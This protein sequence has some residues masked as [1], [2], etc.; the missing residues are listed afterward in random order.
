MLDVIAIL[1]RGTSERCCQ[2]KKSHSLKRSYLFLLQVT[3]KPLITERLDAQTFVCIFSEGLPSVSDSPL[4]IPTSSVS[5]FP[6]CLLSAPD[7]TSLPILP[8][9]FALG[10]FLGCWASPP[11]AKRT[12]VWATHSADVKQWICS[13][14]KHISCLSPTSTCSQTML[15]CGLSC[16]HQQEVKWNLCPGFQDTRVI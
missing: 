13:P 3:P 6:P 10:R 16:Q 7:S 11:S 1:Y 2:F 4:L 15:D 14:Q 8:Y 12:T 5:G 9:C